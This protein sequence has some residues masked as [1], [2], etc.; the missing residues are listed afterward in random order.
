MMQSALLVLESSDTKPLSILLPEKL[1]PKIN[2]EP[3]LIS[4]LCS[5]RHI[6]MLTGEEE[7]ASRIL[8]ERS[9][10]LMPLSRAP[11]HD[12]VQPS[13]GGKPQHLGEHHMGQAQAVCRG[14]DQCGLQCIPRL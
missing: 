3:P 7:S 1:K 2:G 14:Q 12:Y 13:A 11:Y 6:F 8:V 9:L 10:D 4:E 5:R